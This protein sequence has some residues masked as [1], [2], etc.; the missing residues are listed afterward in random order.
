MNKNDN[1]IAFRLGVG[2]MLVNADKKVFVGRR[3]DAPDSEAWQ[4]PQGGIDHPE[5]PEAALWREMKEEVGCNLGEIIAESQEWLTYDLPPDLRLTLWDGQ[6][7]G[8]KQKW[9]LVKFLGEDKDINIQTQ[10]PE[11][12]AWRWADFKELPDLIVPFKRDVYLKV[13]QEFNWYFDNL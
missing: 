6:F 8:Q 10:V 11:F 13:V 3:L 5:T 7:Q 2:I 4:M 12:T 1:S 9:F